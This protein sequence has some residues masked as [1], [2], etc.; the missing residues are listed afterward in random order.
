MQVYNN[1]LRLKSILQSFKHYLVKS[2]RTKRI[3]KECDIYKLE[4]AL[5]SLADK[6]SLKLLLYIL[7]FSLKVNKFI[8]GFVKFSFKTHFYLETIPFK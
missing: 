4:N 1:L 2:L 5:E 7:A 8:Q 6:L 3:C